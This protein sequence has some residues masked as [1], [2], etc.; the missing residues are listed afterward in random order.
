G[1]ILRLR[2][3]SV[4]DAP[5][6]QAAADRGRKVHLACQLWDEADLD[7]ESIA[8]TDLAGYL[9][10]WSRWCGGRP[11]EWALVEAPVW[12]RVEGV[13]FCGVV[14]RVGFV[15]GVVDIKTK[16]ASGRLPKQGSDEWARIGL[17]LAGYRC[18]VAGTECA[19]VDRRQG[20]WLWPNGHVEPLDF[21]PWNAVFDEEWRGLLRQWKAAHAAEEEEDAE[22]SHTQDGAAGPSRGG[23]GE[24]RS[25]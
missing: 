7:E 24:E 5:W 10:G 20:V 8:G 9:A 25:V 21:T 23:S 16:S 11:G 14:D 12:A 1:G 2:F 4:P 18:L 13:A 19:H 3:G 22:D 17:Q 15:R 6:I